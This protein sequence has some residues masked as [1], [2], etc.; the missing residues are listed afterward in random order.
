VANVIK[1]KAY[2]GVEAYVGENLQTVYLTFYKNTNMLNFK[3]TSKN[4]ER[5]VVNFRNDYYIVGTN[6][7]KNLSCKKFEYLM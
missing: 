5:F 4:N 2:T 1:L 7:Y 6:S 3:V